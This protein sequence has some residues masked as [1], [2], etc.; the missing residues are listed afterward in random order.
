MGFTVFYYQNKNTHTFLSKS[1]ASFATLIYLYPLTSPSAL[2][3]TIA[4]CFRDLC[5]TLRDVN[6]SPAQ[7]QHF[8]QEKAA[9][10]VMLS[11]K[12]SELNPDRWAMLNALNSPSA[13]VK[14]SDP[15][16]LQHVSL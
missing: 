12:M 5:V 1:S 7:N 16:S 3:A 4:S 9:V 15:V 8:G 14:S 2:N 10:V 11:V 6:D 13:S